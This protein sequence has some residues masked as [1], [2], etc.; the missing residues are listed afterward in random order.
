MSH[1][2]A[3]TPKTNHLTEV[4]GSTKRGD[5]ATGTTRNA[6]KASP[7]ASRRPYRTREGAAMQRPRIARAGAS[8]GAAGAA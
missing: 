7:S 1:P 6:A 3:I 5:A 2:A 4:N 8:R